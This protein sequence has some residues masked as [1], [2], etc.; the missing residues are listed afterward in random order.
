MDG[1]TSSLPAVEARKWRCII[2]TRA[3]DSRGLRIHRRIKRGPKLSSLVSETLMA[4][5]RCWPERAIMPTAQQTER[6]RRNMG[7]MELEK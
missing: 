2:T 4:E 7:L 3:V 1:M 5:R 6:S